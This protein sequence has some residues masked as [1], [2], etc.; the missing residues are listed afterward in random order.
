MKYTPTAIR[1]EGEGHGATGEVLRSSEAQARRVT[2]GCPLTSNPC[3]RRNIENLHNT[4]EGNK[5]TGDP[6]AESKTLSKSLTSMEEV[7][8]LQLTQI[9][10]EIR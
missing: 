4:E 6:T 8:T 1:K 7:L 2:L 10:R 3:C 5:T 9:K